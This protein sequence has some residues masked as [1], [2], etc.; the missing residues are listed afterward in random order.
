MRN[1]KHVF[2]VYPD[3]VSK[4][5][6]LRFVSHFRARRGLIMVFAKVFS[7]CAIENKLQRIRKNSD[8]AQMKLA[9]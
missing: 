1:S 3:V 8:L 2:N 4:R 7:E 5:P 6:K 9:H